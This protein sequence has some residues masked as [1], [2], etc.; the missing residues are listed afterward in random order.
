[1]TQIST[2]LCKF[3]TENKL[4]RSLG[5]NSSGSSRDIKIS[6]Q[7]HRKHPRKPVQNFVLACVHHTPPH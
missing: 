3:S 5:Y 7:L 1:M 4:K 6:F 2:L